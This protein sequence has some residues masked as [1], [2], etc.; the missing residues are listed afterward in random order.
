MYRVGSPMVSIRD[1]L[2][3]SFHLSWWLTGRTRRESGRIKFRWCGFLMKHVGMGGQ[4]GWL[5]TVQSL[6]LVKL[7]TSTHLQEMANVNIVNYT[8]YKED[9]KKEEW[10]N[11]TAFNCVTLMQVMIELLA[12]CTSHFHVY[13]IQCWTHPQHIWTLVIFS[14]PLTLGVRCN[15]GCSCWFVCL[16][17]CWQL[18]L[19]HRLHACCSSDNFSATN[20]RK[21]KWH[22][23]ETTVFN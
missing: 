19:H 2:W 5:N 15:M 4:M 21:I 17:I 8:Y 16:S 18:L 14:H 1:L 10:Y 6:W 11:L 13:R 22:F 3:N 9:Y 20:T 7:R 12:K 23:F